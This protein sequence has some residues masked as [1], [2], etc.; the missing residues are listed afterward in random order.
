MSLALAYLY[1]LCSSNPSDVEE[2]QPAPI[3]SPPNTILHFLQ[4]TRKQAWH[5]YITHPIDKKLPD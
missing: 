1:N 5:P 4:D 3:L 2:V